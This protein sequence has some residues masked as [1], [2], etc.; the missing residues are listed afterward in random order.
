MTHKKKKAEIFGYTL[1]EVVV[2][3]MVLSFLFITVLNVFQSAIKQLN[4]SRAKIVAAE[5]GN[6]QME[7]IRNLR[8]G[9]VGIVGGLPDGTID[10]SRTVERSN[11][12]FTITTD[13]QYIDD[14]FD[15]CVGATTP[16]DPLKSQC[17][18]GT[19]VDK[20]QDIPANLGNP[21]DYKK[22]DIE[23]TWSPN[24]TGKPLQLSTI[25]S[26]KG[27]EGD[28]TKGFVL[29]KVSNSGGEAIS[30][31]SVQV[32]NDTLIPAFD[33]TFITDIFGNVQ[34]LDVEP[35]DNYVIKVTKGGYTGDRTCFIDAAGT[36]C[37]D[38]EGN[39]DPKNK[40]ITVSAGSY[41]ERSFTIDLISTLEVNS[42]TET[43]SVLPNINLTLQGIKTI[44]NEPSSILKNVLNF[45]TDGSGQ[46]NKNDVN[47]DLYDLIVNSAGYDLAGVNHDLALNILPNTNTVLNVLLTSHTANSLLLTVKDNSGT[48][49]SGATVRLRK[50]GYDET[51]ITGQGFAQQNDWV[52]GS[53]QEN[54][55]D[56]ATKYYS[57]NGHINNSTSGEVSLRENSTNL[58]LSESF[59]TD[60]YKD[61]VNTNADWNT[62]D[63]ELKLPTIA[64]L[65][66][67]NEMHYAQSSK[68]NFQHGK[69]ITATLT[70]TD[71]LNGQNID[72]YISADGGMHFEPVASGISHDIT[73][74]GN[75]LRWRAE[76]TSA[77]DDKT[78]VI[79]ELSVS[80]TILY[81]D[82]TGELISSTYDLGSSATFSTINW[83]S[84]SQPSETGNE[85][86]KFQIATN[87]DNST[88]NF[89]GPDGTAGTYYTSNN[90]V[91]HSSHN[92]NQY[93]RYKAI[94]NTA[95]IYF[96]PLLTNIR[97]GY[98]LACLPPGQVYFKNLDIDTYSVEVKA[99]GYE[100]TTANIDVSGNISQNLLI[101]LIP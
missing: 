5:L 14:P 60:T 81:F 89:I 77:E 96:T 90:A 79:D 99:D 13:I 82:S 41:E 44:S 58:N 71:N 98:T 84:D 15:G 66:P 25:I 64:G 101:N 94:L 36:G 28:T 2:L 69:I 68:L 27:L 48:N 72:Y 92:S 21:A 9:D 24:F 50:T 91:I 54:F 35:A 55:S 42:Y 74:V 26:P 3:V 17:A 46:W 97:I 47:S 85:S 33:H 53:G 1:I 4:F 78:P 40:N 43:C 8:Y 61:V 37:S 62:S 16:Y 12:T 56:D 52:G 88:W 95:D 70:A 18:D 19:I 20:P 10:P 32:I 63:S 75:D 67:V 59:N 73:A 80:Y 76:L 7:I 93:L 45:I 83:E 49:V 30:G 65:Y 39:P 11:I 57:D 51:K 23:I 100:V 87:N 6:E 34:L 22:A 86:L 29:L 31:A 38:A